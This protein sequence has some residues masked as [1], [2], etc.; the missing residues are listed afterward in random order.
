MV[1]EKNQGETVALMGT[2][3]EQS[4]RLTDPSMLLPQT[5]ET[6]APVSPLVSDALNYENMYGTGDLN[7]ADGLPLEVAKTPAE[8]LAEA[9]GTTTTPTQDAAAAD[10]K[11]ETDKK[12][13]ASRA[14]TDSAIASIKDIF[15][16]A[17]QGLQGDKKVPSN[18]ANN[19]EVADAFA[20]EYGAFADPEDV[21]LNKIQD[22]IDATFGD[23]KDFTDS[24]KDAFWMGLMQAGLAMAAGESDNAIT[25]IAK[26]LS[27]GLTQY[28]KDIGELNEQQ[29]EDEKERRLF[30]TQMIRD[31]RSANIAKA[32]NKNQW[33]AASNQMKQ[34]DA[35]EKRTMAWK[36]KKLAIDSAYAMANLETN[37]M[38]SI[39]DLELK[40]DTLDEKA[41]SNLETEAIARLKDTPD[42]LKIA[43]EFGWLDENNNVTEKGLAEAGATLK[44]VIMDAEVLK[45]RGKTSTPTNDD[46]LTNALLAVIGGEGTA[47]DRARI[48]ASPSGQ[49]AIKDA[50]GD[51]VEASKAMFAKMT[52][53]QP[54]TDQA[55][56][57]EVEKQGLVWDPQ[58]RASN[59]R[60]GAYVPPK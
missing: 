23:K 13:S 51:I 33:T 35:A 26:G 10:A 1:L 28:G 53:N 18:Q 55:L 60:S 17:K 14:K 48:L 43:R 8:V 2:A 40:Q 39:A 11:K 58:A 30:K 56:L 9:K 59:G 4:D 54:S 31:E 6:S 15:A 37:M 52:P 25:N 44:Q 42:T 45:A 7:L 20:V 46:K 22:A 34:A 29:R 50:G 24:K 12:P 38:K 47:G 5:G 36:E 3:A 32:A 57:A 41:R 16:K 49:T 21:N 19:P 27:F